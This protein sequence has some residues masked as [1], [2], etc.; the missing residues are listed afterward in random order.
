MDSFEEYT[1]FFNGTIQ[2]DG[3]EMTGNFTDQA[4]IDAL[5]AQAPVMEQKYK[6]LAERCLQSP[7]GKFLKYMGAA[8][9]VRDMVAIADAIEGPGST[10]NYL[11]FS[12]GTVLGAWFIGSEFVLRC[13]GVFSRD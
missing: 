7:S 11:G 3:I 2:V 4:D 1:S 12:Y 8:A 9:T 13:S 10:I 5:F 6:E